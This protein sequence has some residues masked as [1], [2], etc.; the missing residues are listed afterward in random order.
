M[1]PRTMKKIH[2]KEGKEVLRAA[3]IH[4]FL[5]SGVQ[6][7]VPKLHGDTLRVRSYRVRD[8]LFPSFPDKVPPLGGGKIKESRRK[9]NEEKE[10]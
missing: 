7:L 10:Q 4:F 3:A 8:S 5:R 9:E 6:E 1:V 2:N